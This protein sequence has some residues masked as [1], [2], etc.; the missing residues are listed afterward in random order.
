M[1]DDRRMKLY[2]LN[3]N[4]RNLRAKMVKSLRMMRDGEFERANQVL[5]ESK[6]EFD[7]LREENRSIQDDSFESSMGFTEVF[8]EAI[9]QANRLCSRNCSA[10]KFHVYN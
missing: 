1:K 10:I 6:E 8:Y 4:S 7:E 3:S 9:A 5:S 2:Q